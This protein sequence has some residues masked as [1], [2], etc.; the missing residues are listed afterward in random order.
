MAKLDI[1]VEHGQTAEAARSNF[2]KAI[3]AAQKQY[4]Q[5]IQRVEWSNDREVADLSGPG[6]AVRLSFDDRKVYAKGTVPLI[7]KVIEKPIKMFLARV[8][9]K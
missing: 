5:Y 9:K 4:G 3:Q 7:A 2:E 6:F 8:L 1:A